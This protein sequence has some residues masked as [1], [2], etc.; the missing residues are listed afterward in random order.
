[1]G[2]ECIFMDRRRPLFAIKTMAKSQHCT[3]P[4][5]S[6]PRNLIFNNFHVYVP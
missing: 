4:P 2:P 3:K 6:H 5:A 1:M